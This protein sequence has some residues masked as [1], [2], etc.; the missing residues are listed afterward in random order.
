MSNYIFEKVNSP[1]IIQIYLFINKNLE[2]KLSPDSNVSDT[3]YIKKDDETL[4]LKDTNEIYRYYRHNTTGHIYVVSHNDIELD[5]N[6]HFFENDI[7]NSTHTIDGNTVNSGEITKVYK[8]HIFLKEALYSSTDGTVYSPF[9]IQKY[10]MVNPYNDSVTTFNITSLFNVPDNFTINIPTDIFILGDRAEEI[11]QPGTNKLTISKNTFQNIKTKN[12]YLNIIGDVFLKTRCFSNISNLNKINSLGEEILSDELN[13]FLNGI[14]FLGPAGPFKQGLIWAFNS[15]N[16]IFENECMYNFLGNIYVRIDSII[17]NIAGK[18]NVF[19]NDINNDYDLNL[20]FPTMNSINNGFNFNIPEG[21]FYGRKFKYYIVD[22]IATIIENNITIG[23]NCNS[24]GDSAFRNTEIETIQFLSSTNILQLDENCF[25]N[26]INNIDSNIIFE[27]PILLNGSGVFSNCSVK[28][29]HFQN[30]NNF[31]IKPSTFLNTT[32]NET[33]NDNEF[34][35]IFDDTNIRDIECDIGAFANINKCKMYIGYNNLIINEDTTINNRNITIITSFDNKQKFINNFGE[36]NINIKI[37]AIDAFYYFITPDTTKDIAINNYELQLGSEIEN[38]KP[39]NY[40]D[41]LEKYINYKNFNRN[42]FQ[43]KN[44]INIYHL[45][46][47]MDN[48]L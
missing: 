15:N 16:I 25:N 24:I 35:I 45:Y 47:L 11:S 9:L 34:N 31:V 8:N 5:T 46:D 2:F 33:L 19:K 14:P 21:T 28:T 27:R 12:I 13:L 4:K 22:D 32:F 23:S 17:N 26:G 37:I 29:L 39:F 41:Y 48:N 10:G 3:G 30:N 1:K 36:F 43:N 40:D 18:I 7:S 6:I 42:Y 20:I 44:I 38:K